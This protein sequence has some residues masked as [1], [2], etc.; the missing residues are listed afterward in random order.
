MFEK[1]IYWAYLSS[2]STWS[3]RDL[4]VFMT[5]DRVT[6]TYRPEIEGTIKVTFRV[7]QRDRTKEENPDFLK[8]VRLLGT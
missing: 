3:H 7:L 1:S 8:E 5:F 4:I 2:E 6:K